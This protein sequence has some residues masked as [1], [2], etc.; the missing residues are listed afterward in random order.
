MFQ[1]SRHDVLREGTRHPL[2]ACWSL[3][4][5]DIFSL[6]SPW[7]YLLADCTGTLAG[8][9]A[10]VVFLVAVF[11]FAE[12]GEASVNEAANQELAS[13]FAQQCPARA[14]RL[15]IMEVLEG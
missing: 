6:E 2:P 15:R 11:S 13:H 5:P 8:T 10:A 12:C 4:I 9:G 3:E 1:M 7:R 14:A